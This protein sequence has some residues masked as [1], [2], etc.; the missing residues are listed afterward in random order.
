[1]D[2][3]RQ[4][5]ERRALE[6]PLRVGGQPVVTVKQASLYCDTSHDTILRW[7]R[8]NGAY[9]VADVYLIPLCDLERILTRNSPDKVS[10]A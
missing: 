8:A 9:Q 2:K 5:V 3:L 4:D 1:M 6:S 10:A 7:C